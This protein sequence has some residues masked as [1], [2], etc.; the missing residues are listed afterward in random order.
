MVISGKTGCGKST[1]VP[2]F[3]LKDQPN[4]KIAVCQ[5]RRVAASSL[6]VRVAEELNCKV[7]TRVGYHIGMESFRGDN[8]SI[9]YMTYGILIMQLLFNKQLPY[10]HIILDEIHERS[11]EMDF[12][13]VALKNILNSAG[14]SKSKVIVMSATLNA[15]EFANYFAVHAQ[16][17]TFFLPHIIPKKDTQQQANLRGRRQAPE[18][19]QSKYELTKPEGE[20]FPAAAFSLNEPRQFKVDEYFLDDLKQEEFYCGSEVRLGDLAADFACMLLGKIE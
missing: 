2:Q 11:L 10:T 17:R 16:N 20:Y 14:T 19:I 9:V 8:C 5:P 12:T 1:R 6:A 7:G 15:E 18:S 3:I 4:A 13:F